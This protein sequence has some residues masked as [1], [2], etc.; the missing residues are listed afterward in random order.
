MKKLTVIKILAITLALG[1]L[2]PARG[3]VPVQGATEKDWNARSFWYAPWGGNRA[4]I[5]ALIFLR[6]K[7]RALSAAVMAW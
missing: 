1:L 4:C 6:Q 5:K 7:A 3:A 2:L